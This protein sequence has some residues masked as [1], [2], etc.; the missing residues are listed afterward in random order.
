MPT[1]PDERYI[2]DPFV[3]TL[4]LLK[5]AGV[6]PTLK[7]EPVAMLISPS[8]SSLWLGSKTPMPTLSVDTAKWIFEELPFTQLPLSEFTPVRPDP[9]PLNPPVAVTVPVLDASVIPLPTLTSPVATSSDADGDD[10]LIPTW[11]VVVS[12]KKCE[13]PTRRFPTTL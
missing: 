10:V 2:S 13:V 7:V 8:T 3:C 1:F 12:T 11:F 4:Q 6:P 5:T 9:F